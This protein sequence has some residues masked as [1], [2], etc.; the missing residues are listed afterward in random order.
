MPRKLIRSKE[1]VG[2]LL[3]SVADGLA[4]KR[5][6]TGLT[7]DDLKGILIKSVEF[8]LAEGDFRQWGGAP[9]VGIR[10]SLSDGDEPSDTVGL[11]GTTNRR[12]IASWQFSISFSPSNNVGVL[13]F[14]WDA[15][16]GFLVVSD[17]IWIATQSS[18]T[19]Q[20]NNVQYRVFY[21]ITP[22]TVN[23]KLGLI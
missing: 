2:Q 6:P 10:V 12:C 11:A 5:I 19:G 16:A 3:P 23:E 4:K 15:P 8:Q 9:G 13:V 18:F 1:Y 7:P 21:S 20:A 17:E 22:V 14:K